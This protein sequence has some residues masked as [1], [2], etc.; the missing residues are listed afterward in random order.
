M[1]DVL[2]D[3][4]EIKLIPPGEYCCRIMNS[5]VKTSSSG[6]TYVS[7]IIQIIQGSQ[8]GRT[9]DFICHIGAT[10]AKFRFDSRRKFARL[11]SCC[12]ITTS[13]T[14]P[15]VLLD[16]MLLVEIGQSKDKFGDM[17]NILG[18]KKLQKN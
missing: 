8:Q 4:E 1:S 2:F 18:F 12:G 9:V 16:K 10:D 7:T 15:N 3:P 11:V 14:D 5:E 17:N 13:I 6:N